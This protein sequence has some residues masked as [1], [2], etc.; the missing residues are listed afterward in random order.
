MASTLPS[1]KLVSPR[2]QI[3]AGIVIAQALLLLKGCQGG[4]FTSPY[5]IDT[6]IDTALLLMLLAVG[7]R[8]YLQPPALTLVGSHL[9]IRPALGRSSKI[10]WNEVEWIGCVNTLGRRSV[11]ITLTDYASSISIVRQRR[12]S[13]L[14][15]G[16]DAMV[17]L[18]YG[19]DADAL[20]AELVRYWQAANSGR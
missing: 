12:L 3:V 4:H 8:A 1:R 19:L 10:I 16:C 7:V 11:G 17:G 20:A 6:A 5:G 9:L 2:L 13:R 18:I 15:S 14:M